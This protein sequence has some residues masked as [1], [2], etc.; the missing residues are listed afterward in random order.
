MKGVVFWD[1]TPCSQ[2]SQPTSRRKVVASILINAIIFL[3]RSVCTG[4]LIDTSKV[5][6]AF[7][8][9]LLASA[10]EIDVQM[11]VFFVD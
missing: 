3:G 11:S 1:I 9:L 7:L 10:E 2:L 6:S 4:G 8:Q 5:I